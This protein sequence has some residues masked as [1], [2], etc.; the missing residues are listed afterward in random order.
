RAPRSAAAVKI[1]EQRMR[2]LSRPGV[3]TALTLLTAL[4]AGTAGCGVHGGAFPTVV[5]DLRVYGNP[6]IE[7]TPVHYAITHLAAAPTG[8]S[9]GGIPA[10]FAG[11]DGAEADLAGHA[12][13]QA[14]RNSLVHP[15][16]R[17]ILTITEGHY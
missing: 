4:A 2:H 11:P 17:I 6:T 8:V 15:E 1:Q 3:V 5:E 14:L 12:E 10:L 9:R 7:L 13:I 16:I